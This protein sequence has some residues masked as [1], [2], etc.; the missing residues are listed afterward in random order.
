MFINQR[1]C[2]LFC[3]LV[4]LDSFSFASKYKKE[5]RG[6]GG[7]GLVSGT[8][9]YSLTAIRRERVTADEEKGGYRWYTFH[10]HL[11]RKKKCLIRMR[12]THPWSALGSTQIQ[13]RKTVRFR[14]ATAWRSFAFAFRGLGRQL[15]RSDSIA[16]TASI[17][18]HCVCGRRG[19]LLARVGRPTGTVP[20]WMILKGAI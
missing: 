10:L 11:N 1:R 19:S 7:G 4:K 18:M 14:T 17:G 16:R 8:H 12:G 13:R 20:L 5:R 9:K 2:A 6:G 15:L 3:C